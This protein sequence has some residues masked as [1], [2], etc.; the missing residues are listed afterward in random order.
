MGEIRSYTFNIRDSK[1]VSCSFLS[2]DLANSNVTSLQLHAFVGQANLRKLELRYNSIKILLPKTFSELKELDRLDLS[3]NQI[4]TLPEEVFKGLVHLTGLNLKGNGI[5]SI[6]PSAFEDLAN[7][8]TLNLRNNSLRKLDGSMFQGLVSVEHI[9]FDFNNIRSI[10]NGT[11]DG[12]AYLS[13]LDLE[14]NVLNKIPADLLETA[15]LKV[16][17]LSSN[18]FASLQFGGIS[19]DSLEEVTIRNVQFVELEEAFT[20]GFPNVR[21]MDL[22]G[23]MLT[24]LNFSVFFHNSM[25]NTLNFSSN[26]ISSLIISESVELP[27]LKVLDL[28]NNKLRDFDYQSFFSTLPG[29]LDLNLGSNPFSCGLVYQLTEFFK[30]ENV[31]VSLSNVPNCTAVGPM[32]NAPMITPQCPVQ[33]T[34]NIPSGSNQSTTKIY[35]LEQSGGWINYL[36]LVLILVLFAV[37]LGAFYKISSDVKNIK[38]GDNNSIRV[39]LLDM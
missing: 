24:Q 17:D 16:L 4:K 28:S 7:L 34:R 36:L 11:F 32:L 5:E 15:K 35:Y 19:S 10:E 2:I 27:S 29:A 33:S 30:F 20:E 22:S 13:T 18:A 8:Q 9:L 3:Y 38:K 23:N 39:P 31:K 1:G 14:H 26:R 37:V 6:K 12:L 25:L 21:K